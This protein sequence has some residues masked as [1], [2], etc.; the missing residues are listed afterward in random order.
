MISLIIAI[1]GACWLAGPGVPGFKKSDIRET[2]H[3]REIIHRIL[4]RAAPKLA[5]C[6]GDDRSEVTFDF[7]VKNAGGHVRDVKVKGIPSANQKRCLVSKAR[8]IKF[9]YVCKGAKTARIQAVMTW[10]E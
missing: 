4:N 9:G 2:G 6:L 8:K 1:L 10:S 3:N 5:A 7:V